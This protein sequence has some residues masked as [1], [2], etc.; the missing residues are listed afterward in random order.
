[1]SRASA[2]LCLLLAG[3]AARAQAPR[4]YSVGLWGDDARTV[5]CVTGAAGDVVPVEGWAWSPGEQG[6]RY[7][8]LR[9]AIPADVEP[10]GRPVFHPLVT[11]VVI[12]PYVDGTVEWNM[13]L[14]D[15]PPGWVRVFTQDYRLLDTAPSVLAIH[16]ANSWIRDCTFALNEPEVLNDLGINDPGC[17][18]VPAAPVAWGA[19]HAGYRGPAAGR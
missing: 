10:V 3:S 1:M 15:C 6:L 2:V 18:S 7:V 16:G 13:L 12:T 19:L 4:D 8:T 17:G 9:L 14:T 5:T 11:D